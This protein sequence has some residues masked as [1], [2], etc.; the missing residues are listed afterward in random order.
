MFLVHNE[1]A[2]LLNW[3][4]WRVGGNVQSINDDIG[5]RIVV[6]LNAVLA[7]FFSLTLCLAFERDDIF[8]FRVCTGNC[9]GGSCHSRTRM[10]KGSLS[11][12]LSP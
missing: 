9:S 12:S 11:C 1:L 2:L 6:I 7:P 10:P 3:H 8:M 4:T 5:K